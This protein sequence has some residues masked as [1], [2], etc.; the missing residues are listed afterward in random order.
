MGRSGLGWGLGGRFGRWLLLLQ[1]GDGG[2]L[3]GFVHVILPQ[4]GDVVRQLAL[5]HV[6]LWHGGHRG[7]IEQ[8]LRDLD[9]LDLDF[10]HDLRRWRVAASGKRQGSCAGEGLRGRG[11]S[12]DAGADHCAW[13]AA[14]ARSWAAMNGGTCAVVWAAGASC[15]LW[16]TLADV[17]AALARPAEAPASAA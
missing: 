17:P 8:W 10:G 4:P 6:D 11:G 9:A 1:R 16:L 13:P 15:T 3:G 7:D 12:A 5:G 14:S 2:E